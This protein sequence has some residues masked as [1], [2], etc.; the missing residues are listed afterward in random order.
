MNRDNIMEEFNNLRKMYKEFGCNYNDSYILDKMRNIRSIHI[1][2]ARSYLRHND[3]DDPL[4]NVVLCGLI[5]LED[6]VSIID[7]MSRYQLLK[8]VKK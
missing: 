6:E 2:D 8:E 4:Y 7:K 3:V 5:A 1:D